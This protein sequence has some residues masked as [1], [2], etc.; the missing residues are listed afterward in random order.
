MRIN[1]FFPFAF[2][3]FFLNILGLPF[4]LT[5]VAVLGPFFYIWVVLKRK[6]DI[7]LPFLALLFP[8]LFMQIVVV[9]VELKTYIISLLNILM[10]YFFCQAVYTFFKVCEDPEP[11]FRRILIINFIFCLIGIIFY[12]TPL[13][14]WF[15]IEQEFTKGVTNFRRFKLF[16][17][18]ASYYATLFVPI[19]F[20]FLLQYVFMQNRITN[21]WLLPM[22]FLPFILS[23]SIGVIAASILAGILTTLV[24][25]RQLARKRRVV[26]MFINVGVTVSAILV[27][28]VFYFR[29]N[30]L[31][32]RIVNIFS[33]NDSSAAGRTKDAFLLAQKMLE[34]KNEYWGIGMG[35]LKILGHDIVNDY[36]LYNKEF[37]AAIPNA[38]AETWAVF[39]WV[40]IILK[41]LIEIT[42]FFYTRVWTN[43]YRLM[44][45]FFMFVYQFTGSFL[46]NIA[47]Y[48]IWILAFTNVFRQ[49][50]VRLYQRRS[51]ASI[52]TVS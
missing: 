10:V 33:G 35:Q 2:L 46:T 44:L 4:G 36:Y 47:E 6:K 37:V 7:L 26:N 17:Y 24:Y 51:A 27:I 22:L 30:P 8:F 41:L 49:F 18:E 42:L 43:Y 21:Y 23:F 5:W 32:V 28:L 3:Y 45:F 50:D 40:G 13:D 12:F 52:I 38:T 25:F 20:F 29:N 48:V 39:G 31:F 16:T 14:H 11:I 15:W 34:E 1:K 9:G 19:F